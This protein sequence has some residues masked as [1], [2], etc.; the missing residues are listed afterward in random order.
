MTQPRNQQRTD[1]IQSGASATGGG[2]KHHDY[3]TQTLFEQI[4]E[5]QVYSI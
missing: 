1:R 2:G 4:K 5:K 3:P